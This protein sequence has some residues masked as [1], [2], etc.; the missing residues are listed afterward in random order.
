MAKLPRTEVGQVAL[1]PTAAEM[2]REAPRQTVR[3]QLVEALEVT[4]N[5]YHRL[6]CPDKTAFEDCKYPACAD[7]RRA[8]DRARAEPEGHCGCDGPDCPTWAAGYH[9]G[10]QAGPF[11]DRGAGTHSQTPPAEEAPDSVRALDPA[12]VGIGIGFTIVQDGIPSGRLCHI[13]PAHQPYME[14]AP[15]WTCTCG[16]QGV[17]ATVSDAVRDV[18]RHYWHNHADRRVRV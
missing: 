17:T 9:R 18:R 5:H 2:G 13:L 15:Q 16:A 11:A 6:W 10:K 1:P 4:A 8:L 12:Y 7:N 14:G 3:E